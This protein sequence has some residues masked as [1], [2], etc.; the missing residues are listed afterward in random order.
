MLATGIAISPIPIAAI[1]LTMM[2]RRGVANGFGFLAGWLIALFLVTGCGAILWQELD[3]FETDTANDDNNFSTAW[4]IV[5]I[6][7]LV[8]SIRLGWQYMKRNRSQPKVPAWMKMI[9]HFGPVKSG[10]F[11]F[12]LTIANVKNLPLAIEAAGTLSQTH[13]LVSGLLLFVSIASIGVAIPVAAAYIG[14]QSAVEQLHRWKLWL[15]HHNGA[16]LCVLFLI[17]GIRAVLR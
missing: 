15:Q 13:S 12:V 2:T 7:F 9:E 6:I 8:L 16:I 4:L 17:L 1:I 14:K 10:V 11:G 5:G 3:Q